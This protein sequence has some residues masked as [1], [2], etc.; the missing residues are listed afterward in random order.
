MLRSAVLAAGF[1]GAAVPAF[2]ASTDD[3]NVTIDLAKQYGPSYA[4]LQMA[5][6]QARTSSFVKN[7]SAVVTIVIPQG[8]YDFSGGPAKGVINVSGIQPGPHGQLIIKG[9]G[10]NL[11][12]ESDYT[13]LKF[14]RS[15]IQIYGMGASNV[16]FRGIHFTTVEPTV[17][18]GYVVSVSP[19]EIAL[20]VPPGFPTPAEI[21]DSG[22]THGRY[23]RRCS[24]QERPP[25]ILQ[26]DNLQ[27]PWKSVTKDAARS[28][29]GGD[30]WKFTL[31][32]MNMNS[33]EI[34]AALA[35]YAKAGTDQIVAI[36]SK[37][38]GQT[39]WFAK[40][41]SITFDHVKWTRKSR[42]VFRLGSKN[43]RF[44]FAQI[45]REK[46]P[47]P[48]QPYCLSTPE[49]GPQFGQPGDERTWGN[50]VDHFEAEGT[51]DD[52]IAF[53]NNSWDATTG[54]PSTVGVPLKGPDG[55][56]AS[57]IPSN[58]DIRDSFGRGILLFQSANVV[59]GAYNLVRA[60]LL[61]TDVVGPAD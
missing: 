37:S 42:G 58:V 1:I 25:K 23:L 61:R 22:M 18:Q 49:G 29:P 36:K 4:G 44:D 41:D 3:S 47:D 20:R 56:P 30:V 24:A 43:I 27:I 5:I 15:A 6:D 34:R 31:D 13:T 8:T 11:N 50:T 32:T 38:V 39:Y 60:P 12:S 19:T 52:A 2:A 45:R 9:A 7:P 16:T 10:T 21:F 48:S 40:S 59:L 33:P 54:S 51:G 55:R 53:F 17:S 57:N 35:A 46:S 14:S 26:N 28:G